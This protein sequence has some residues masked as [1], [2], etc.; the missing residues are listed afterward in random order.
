M[1]KGVVLTQETQAAGIHAQLCGS[2]LTEGVMISY[3]P[4]AH[5]Y[6]VSLAPATLLEKPVDPHPSV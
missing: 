5:I 6:A 2:E 1:P 4:L 3:L